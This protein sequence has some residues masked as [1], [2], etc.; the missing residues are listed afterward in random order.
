[1]KTL[2]LTALAALAAAAADAASLTSG[3][4][5]QSEYADTEATT[6][7]TFALSRR[8]RDF[9]LS[10]ELTATPSNNVQVAFG[11]DADEDGV[12]ALAE[13]DLIVG[14]DCGVW[15]VKS[16]DVATSLS[17]AP[18]TSAPRKV[19]SWIARVRHCALREWSV[20]ENDVPLFESAA[21]SP[22]SWFYNPSWNCL[23]VTVRGVDVSGDFLSFEANE[24]GCALSVR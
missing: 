15:F 16:P 23:R 2:L 21:E 24:K 18:V 17:S 12:L 22:E 11:C 1:M 7:F 3:P 8:I 20:T 9:L 4:L 14:W 13:T 6:N 19:L 10:V 5:P